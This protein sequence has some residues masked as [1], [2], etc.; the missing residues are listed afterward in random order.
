MTL[1]QE[2]LAIAGADGLMLVVYHPDA[3]SGDA[4]KLALLAMGATR[5]FSNY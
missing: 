2:R 4:E 1:N 3:G 5:Y